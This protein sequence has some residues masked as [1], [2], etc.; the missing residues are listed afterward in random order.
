MINVSA[1]ASAAINGTSRKFR[2]RFLLDG[3]AIDGSIKNITVNKGSCGESDFVPGALYSSFID[4]T[5]DYCS[6]ALEK[7]ELLL[8]FGVLVGDDYEWSDIGYFTVVDPATTAYTTTFTGVGRLSSKAGKLYSTKLSYPTTIK[9]VLDE[10]SSQIG[11]TIDASAFNTSGVINVKP[12]GYMHREMLAFIAG[13]FFGYVT[14]TADGKIKFE[15]FSTENIVETNGDRTTQLPTFSDIDTEVTGVSVTTSVS[16]EDGGAAETFTTGVVNVA[17]ANPF[18]TQ[19]LFNANVG[20]IIGFKFRS[21]TVPISMGDYR[22]EAPDCLR[23][24]DVAKNTYLVPCMHV[25]HVFDGGISTYVLAPTF[26]AEDEPGAYKGALAIKMERYEADLIT[27]KQILAQKVSAEEVEAIVGNFDF[28][29]TEDLDANFITAENLDASVAKLGYIT[30]TDLDADYAKIQDL[31][32]LNGEFETLKADAVTT[33]TLSVKV[34]ELGYAKATD[35]ETTNAK[36]TS[37]EA[38]DASIDEL[39]AKKASVEDLDAAEARIGTLE[40]DAL[41]VD[42]LSTEVAKLGY[43]TVGDLNVT[44]AKI[45]DLEAKAITTDNIEV[46]IAEFDFLTTTSANAKYANIDFSNIGEAAIVKLFSES[47]IIEDLTVSD[48]KITGE[49]VGVTIKG[50]LIEG[51]TVKADKL[52]VKGTDG[53]YYKLNFE[54]GNFADGEVVPDDGLHGSVIVANSI[55][56]EKIQVDDLVAFGASI[57][58]FNITDDAIYSGVKDSVD[59]TTNGIYMDKDGQ[60]VIGDASNFVKFYKDESDNYKLE[61][62]AQSLKFSSSDKTVAEEINGLGTELI[63]YGNHIRFSENGICIHDGNGAQAIELWLESGK[64][65]FFRNEQPFGEWDGVNFKTGNIVIE[66]NK[67]AQIGEYAFIPRGGDRKH[68]SLLKVE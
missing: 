4:A 34:A 6:I 68:M 18:M 7:K 59:N 55:T 53:L 40:T 17:I 49:L 5:I 3:K 24:T 56:A 48:G 54:S 45:D 11:V 1:N 12:S 60:M 28:I 22:L 27:A 29:T 63:K 46:K 66:L 26:T 65:T 2:A 43:A 41:K 36:I 38:K 37:L 15:R 50:D 61:I 44:D 19:A 47:G 33:D 31:E 9:N 32:A 20:N 57:G 62:S 21:G 14:E 51:N 52:V 58:G 39:V 25:K 13:I 30:A 10:I 8:Q 42:E 64:I 23:V 67:R 16:G 35:L